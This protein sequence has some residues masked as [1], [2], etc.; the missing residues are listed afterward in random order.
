MDYIL[1]I[2]TNVKLPECDN[3]VMAAQDNVLVHRNY[4]LKYLGV[5][6]MMPTTYFQKV[7]SKIVYINMIYMCICIKMLVIGELGENHMGIH[8]TDLSTFLKVFQILKMGKNVRKNAE[9][10]LIHYL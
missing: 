10:F 2:S 7:Q 9:N 4:M 1:E 3:C 5:N 6:G 8:Y